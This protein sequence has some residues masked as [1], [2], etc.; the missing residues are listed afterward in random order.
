MSVGNSET[1]VVECKRLGCG[2][3]TRIPKDAVM[4]TCPNCGKP[5]RVK[6]HATSKAGEQKTL[7]PTFISFADA[8][9]RNANYYGNP[10]WRDPTDPSYD[11]NIFAVIRDIEEVDL[12]NQRRKL[13][14]VPRDFRK[15]NN[16]IFIVLIIAALIVFAGCASFFSNFFGGP[17]TY[18]DF[19]LNWVWMFP[20]AIG[21]VLVYL[22]HVQREK[23]RDQ[24]RLVLLEYNENLRST[25]WSASFQ[26]YQAWKE[27]LREVDPHLHSQVTLWEQ[28]EKVLENQQ[29]LI[30]QQDQI[31]A[32]Q[33][34]SI[35]IQREGIDAQNRANVTLEQMRR[36]AELRWQQFQYRRNLG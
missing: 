36:D 8:A 20:A 27:I 9:R 6:A 35:R 12:E 3:R 24:S 14:F 30:S 15:L 21:I 2:H 16:G 23:K 13:A 11:P 17:H 7:P 26:R 19:D 22:N 5:A 29:R 1:H 34:E 33:A 32:N 18:D 4:F 28:Q 25:V 31:L 10:F